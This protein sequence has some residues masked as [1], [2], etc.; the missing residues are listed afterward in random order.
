VSGLAATLERASPLAR[1]RARRP[2]TPAGASGRGLGAAEVL[3]VVLTAVGLGLRLYQL[4]RPGYLLGVDEYDDAVDF[5]SAVR[6]VHG[7]L[8][9][10]DFVLVQPPGITLLMAPVALL[11]K[12]VGLAT[13]FAVARVLTACAGAATIALAGWLVRERGPVAVTIVCGVLAV[14]PGALAA[15]HTVLLEPW[16]TL[17]C[18][19]GALALFEGEELS[20]RRARLVWG[21][22]AFGFAGA[23]KVWAVLPVAVLLILGLRLWP[24]RSW[25]TYL[26]GVVA[27]FA[28]AVLPFALSAPRAF[29]RD[30]IVAQLS[31]VDVARVPWH[32]R[33]SSLAGL[34]DFS[35][36]GARAILAGALAIAAVAAACLALATVRE[37]RRPPALELF[38]YG[39][40]LAVLAAFLWPSDYYPHYAAFFAPFLALCLGLPAA[41]GLSGLRVL[42]ALAV[43]VGL[44]AL[45]PMTAAE[46]HRI[47]GL[48]GGTPGAW[49]QR[50]IPAGS[51][52][53]TDLSALTIVADRFSSARPG[54]SPMIDPIGSD[55]ALSRGHNGV[56]GA[57]YN[58]AVKALWLDALRHAQYVWLSCAPA[59]APGCN[60]WTNRRIPWTPAILGYFRA[61]FRPV[62]GQAPPAHI[63]VRSDSHVGAK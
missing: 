11:S 57:G 51:C 37:R 8:P 36:P 29:Y 27:G 18:L 39:S 2:R 20:G 7:F 15:A 31:R 58:P 13:G 28:L 61:H 43:V 52:V 23:I 9:Y 24:R 40:A 59:A 33:V 41:R 3:I 25:L 54:C 45:V 17:F 48:S 1:A 53:L 49:A 63:F 34:S 44:L 46:A 60:P 21:G 30:V 16:L 56:T 26:G 62:P 6:L 10:H 4:M 19:L 42:P 12:A 22:L 5:G 50:R 14:Y 38:A 55:Y 47:G 32:E 35:H